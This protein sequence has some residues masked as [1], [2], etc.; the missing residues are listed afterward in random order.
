MI[1]WE[2]TETEL[3]R[4][5]E[6][7]VSLFHVFGLTAI[8]ETV[9]AFS[10]AR[11]GT[12][13]D[14]GSLHDIWMRVSR[15]GGRSFEKP[16]ILLSNKGHHCWTNPVPVYDRETKRLFL[17][18]SDND[19]NLRTDSFIMYSDNLGQT[20]STPTPVA[21][22]ESLPF[23]LAGPGHGI[24][25]E[26]G[27]L[28]VP[29][30]HRRGLDVLADRRGYC[31]SCLASDDHG[32][33]WRMS[34]MFGQ[35]CHAS[36]S[37]IV[38]TD[39]GLLWVVRPGQPG[40][41]GRYFC[42]SYDEGDTWTTMQPLAIGPANN[43]DDGLIS[44]GNIVLLSRISWIEKRR[45]MEILISTNSGRTFTQRMSLMPGDAM[46]GYS[47][48]CLLPGNEPT[49]GLLHCRCNHVLFSRISLQALT[50]GKHGGTERKVWLG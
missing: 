39:D 7:N 1:P 46:P 33:S 32:I 8:G 34:E 49:I 29:F 50:S 47:D 2:Y 45:D 24:Q 21:M 31:V 42:R 25:L 22:P 37:R 18:F 9:L 43:C 5:G 3:W 28:L 23:H 19:E 26:S 17:F 30:W 13:S 20:W 6:A 36:E 12:A 15:D 41:T 38:E 44:F 27:R 4:I 11:Y 14:A 40:D 16:V 35:A 48:L 10:E